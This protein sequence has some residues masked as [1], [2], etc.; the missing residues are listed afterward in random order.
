[1]HPVGEHSVA[2]GPLSPRWLAWSLDEPRAGATSTA[3]L[4]LENAGTATWRSRGE[5][6]VQASFHWLD[7]LGN[8]I[9]WDGPRTPLPRE[10]APGEA[11]ELTLA[12][13]A[14]RPPGAYRLAFDLVEEH[15][16]WFAE[17]G[18]TPLDLEIS[19]APRIADRTLAVHVHGGPDPVTAAALAAQE[20]AVVE[21]ESD[22][23]A[24]A[25]LVAGAAPPPSWSRLLLD[26]HAEGW[27]A[28]GT[29][30][31]PTGRAR[32]LAP[33]RGGGGRNPRFA[34]PLLLPSL[35][36]GI[37]PTEHLGLPAYDGEERL[38]DGR[39][40]V[41]VPRRSGRRQS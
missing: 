40:A 8:P 39:V 34:H 24:V 37:E 23:A 30:L 31:A 27:V 2:A 3:R 33:W 32:E 14:P 25:H 22:A 26:A 18:G 5:D 15:R 20:E 21:S 6:G 28:V 13:T 19:V 16:F 7:P 12:V 10:V 11:V 35:L 29:A 4:S 41:T 9:V 36:D 38:F 1:V 17:V